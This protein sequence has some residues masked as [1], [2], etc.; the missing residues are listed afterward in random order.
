[1]NPGIQTIVNRVGKFV[2]SQ[3]DSYY[4]EF[5]YDNFK[6]TTD[7]QTTDT[8]ITFDDLTFHYSWV[9]DFNYREA[10]R[11]ADIIIEH[12]KI[13]YQ[14][15]KQRTDKYQL[16]E[17]ELIEKITD[18]VIQKM[19]VTNPLNG[20]SYVDASNF[21]ENEMFIIKTIGGVKTIAPITINQLKIL[22]GIN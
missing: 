8:I 9:E 12:L 11:I 15:Y 19:N 6:V 22:L 14:I 10:I 7:Q 4:R 20:L 13:S 16:T 2:S 5:Y 21:G 1:M 18:K 17:A 3:E